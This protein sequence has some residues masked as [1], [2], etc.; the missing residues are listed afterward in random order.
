MHNLIKIFINP[1]VSSGEKVEEA[2]RQ[3]IKY[4]K[5]AWSDR[6]YGLERLVQ[7]FLCVVQFIY[8]MLL[9]RDIF[10]RAGVTSRKMAGEFYA[11]LKWLFP[12]LVLSFGLYRHPTIIIVIVYLLSETIFHILSLIFLS[13]IHG[14]VP[15]YHR[16]ILLL[17]LHYLEVVFDF[18]VVYIGLGLLS[19][20]LTPVSAVYFSLVASTTVGFGDIHAQGT[21]G[22]LIVIAQLIVCVLFIILF[23]NY[24]LQRKER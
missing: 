19:Q 3:Q 14:M 6:T 24:F 13:D 5:R 10:G 18:A 20:T 4:L 22:Q 8:P 16:S 15:S 1:E 7:L 17:F 12:L 23:I 11:V 2:Y 21:I 9:V